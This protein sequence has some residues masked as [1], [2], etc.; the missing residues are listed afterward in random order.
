MSVWI[1]NSD[2]TQW[3]TFCFS[4]AAFKHSSGGLAEYSSK[5]HYNF[6]SLLKSGKNLFDLEIMQTYYYIKFLMHLKI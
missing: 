3:S 1:A 4:G 5:K 2:M 6:V